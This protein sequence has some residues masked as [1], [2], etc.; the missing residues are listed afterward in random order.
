M[1][2]ARKEKKHPLKWG[3]DTG[4]LYG[5]KNAER[6]Q[7]RGKATEEGGGSVTQRLTVLKGCKVRQGG[8]LIRKT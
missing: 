8:L 5:K 2:P 3:R 4:S 6:P 7:G 1:E